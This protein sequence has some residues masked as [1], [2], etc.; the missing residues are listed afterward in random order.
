MYFF[1][2]L[3]LNFYLI[4]GVAFGPCYHSNLLLLRHKRIFPSITNA[5]Q[6]HPHLV[7]NPSFGG[8]GGWIFPAATNANTN[9]SLPVIKLPALKERNI[10]AWGKAL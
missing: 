9:T 5:I 4:L 8:W 1:Y 7:L 6:I 3:F 2:F 10:L